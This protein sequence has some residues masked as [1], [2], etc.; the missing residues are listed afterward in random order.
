MKHKVI[1][2]GQEL[3]FDV[4]IINTPNFLRLQDFGMADKFKSE[5]VK[6]ETE[7]QGVS[8]SLWQESVIINRVEY[9]HLQIE[10][11]I[12]HGQ[13]EISASPYCRAYNSLTDAASKKLKAELGESLHKFAVDNLSAL[14]AEM[15][16]KFMQNAKEK[17]AEALL[18]FEKIENAIEAA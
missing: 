1:F 6:I 9:Q 15:T 13:T 10:F 12:W 17:I 2:D 18:E 5:L 16:E 4:S 7:P 11:K 8:F 3:E 14:Q